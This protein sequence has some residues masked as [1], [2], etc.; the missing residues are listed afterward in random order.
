MEPLF[1][2]RDLRLVE[3]LEYRP[4]L[5]TQLRADQGLPHLGG[6][7]TA[8]LTPTGY[9]S[10]CDLWIVRSYI[11]RRAVRFRC[12]LPTLRAPAVSYHGMPP[13]RL[14]IVS[15]SRWA[16]S[17]ASLVV[18]DL[19]VH[20]RLADRARDQGLCGRSNHDG[21]ERH[22]PHPLVDSGCGR[23]L[24]QMDAP[25]TGLRGPPQPVGVGVEVERLVQPAD[26]I[27]GGPPHQP[28]ARR[29]VVAVTEKPVVFVDLPL[30]AGDEIELV[31]EPHLRGQLPGIPSV[32]VF[33][34]RQ[35]VAIR[36]GDGFVDV[37]RLADRTAERS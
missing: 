21:R 11:H 7:A 28:S 30:V 12:G 32:V 16:R 6:R 36:A 17:T 10:L 3:A 23:G 20:A 18:S 31:Q 22:V 9:E 25:H 37:P 13:N 33:Q 15:K 4:D 14:L 2:E 24:N 19:T 27:P 35:R 26:A 29:R 5:G 34:E 8:G 1:S